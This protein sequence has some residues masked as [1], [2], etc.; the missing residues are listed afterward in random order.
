MNTS[1]KRGWKELIYTSLHMQEHDS[2]C[3]R[4][5]PLSPISSLNK[6]ANLISPLCNRHGHYLIQ[7]V[8]MS[9]QLADDGRK[10]PNMQRSTTELHL[11]MN[12]SPSQQF[13]EKVFVL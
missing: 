7:Q 9:S 6:I 12:P 13:M 11:K 8:R 2:A 10:L 3:P 1:K 5:A 4:R